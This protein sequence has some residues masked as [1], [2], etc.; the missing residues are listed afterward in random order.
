MARMEGAQFGLLQ[1]GMQFDLVQHR[2]DAGFADDP[3]QI[4]HAEIRHPDRGDLP[5]IPQRDQR[6]PCVKEPVLCRAGPVDQHQIDLR[7]PD[8]GQAFRN[9]AARLIRALPVIPDLGGDKDLLARQP[10]PAQPFAKP[11]FIAI[12]RRPVDQPIARRHPLDHHPRGLVGRHLPQAKADL[13]QA[14]PIV[15]GKHRRGHV[16]SPRGFIRHTRYRATAD[17]HPQP[18]PPP[19]TRAQRPRRPAGGPVSRQ[20]GKMVARGGLE[21]PTLRL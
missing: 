10:H 14:A 13:G 15:Q 21:P 3:L 5:F 19:R 8:P 20:G 16:A 11:L 17:F 2:H 6:L 4:R 18:Q 12:D 9:R 1:A 7:H